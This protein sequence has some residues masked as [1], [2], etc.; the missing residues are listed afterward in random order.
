M[1]DI[2]GIEVQATTYGVEDTAARAAAE[3]AENA[4]DTA[5]TAVKTL[6]ENLESDITE[7]LKKYLPTKTVLWTNPNLT[8]GMESQFL[9]IPNMNEYDRLELLFSGPAAG[10]P[11]TE[12]RTID[13]TGV[14][15]V[16]MKMGGVQ[17]IQP[18]AVFTLSSR[19]I[20]VMKQTNQIIVDTAY[21]LTKN[22]SNE[23]T[24]SEASGRFCLYQ[25]IGI[26][27][28]AALPA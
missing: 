24:V 14:G 4:A 17:S 18:N 26:K 12:V 10:R 8:S 19:G 3:T 16:E 2:K 13:L 5:A 6:Q 11:N 9:T 23:Y 21:D 15:N 1:A 20:T 27:N 28:G 25:V 7:V 22:Y